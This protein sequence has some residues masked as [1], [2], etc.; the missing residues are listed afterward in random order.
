MKIAVLGL[1]FQVIVQNYWNRK[2]VVRQC[3]ETAEMFFFLA[4]GVIH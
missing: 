2:E 1:P 3:R 4:K